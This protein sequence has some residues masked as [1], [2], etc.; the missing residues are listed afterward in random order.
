VE[1]LLFSSQMNLIK[2]SFSCYIMLNGL[3]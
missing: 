2:L 1:L 3:D